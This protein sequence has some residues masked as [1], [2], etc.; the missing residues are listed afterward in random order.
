MDNPTFA[1]RT[2]ALKQAALQLKACA[3]TVLAEAQ[4]IEA[5]AKR[6]AQ[7]T[8]RPARQSY[9]RRCDGRREMRCIFKAPQT[10]PA[11]RELLELTPT[12]EG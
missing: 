7:L 4:L 3:E 10:N 1:E 5:A 11:L 6:F 12:W 8:K 2:A 9:L